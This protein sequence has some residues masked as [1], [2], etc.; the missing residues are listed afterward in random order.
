MAESGA[1]RAFRSV[2]IALELPL[3]ADHTGDAFG[4]RQ[5]GL[6]DMGS[7][8]FVLRRGQRAL[9]V[10]PWLPREIVEVTLVDAGWHDHK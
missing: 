8:A 9:A 7:I 10:L 4:L 6:V 2:A 3:P 5:L 1:R